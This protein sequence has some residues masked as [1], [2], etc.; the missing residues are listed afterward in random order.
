MGFGS[1]PSARRGGSLKRSGALDGMDAMIR[2][3]NTTKDKTAKKCATAGVRAGLTPLAKAMRAAINASSASTGLKRAARKTI[4]KS[5]RRY[6]GGKGARGGKAGFAVGKPPKKKA[7]AAHE[8]SVY[9]Q[10]GAKM[11]KGVG[12]SSANIHWYVLGTKERTLTKGPRA[13][14]LE[15][16]NDFITVQN[17]GKIT[18]VFK[19][20][21]PRATVAARGAML[22]A[23]RKKV[24]QVLAKELAKTRK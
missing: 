24:T 3:L 21:V 5:L 1:N 12:V 14:V 18:G 20:V 8:R 9:G 22:E 4:G 2:T 6:R 13:V 19:G 7:A 17:T 15:E 23:A 16:R 11:A 10:R